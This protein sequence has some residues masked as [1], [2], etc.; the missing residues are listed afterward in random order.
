MGEVPVFPGHGESLALKNVRFSSSFFL[1]SLSCPRTIS[2]P[3]LIQACVFSL[4]IVIFHRSVHGQERYDIHKNSQS[5]VVEVC[6][7]LV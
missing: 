4:D 3:P 2:V 1:Y 5:I 7:R 6:K